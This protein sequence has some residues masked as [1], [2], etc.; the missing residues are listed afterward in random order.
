MYT[1]LVGPLVGVF[2]AHDV[3]HLRRQLERRSLDTHATAAAVWNMCTGMD[4]AHRYVQTALA[5]CRRLRQ[6]DVS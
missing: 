4:M 6:G 2:T 3:D 1:R 5:M